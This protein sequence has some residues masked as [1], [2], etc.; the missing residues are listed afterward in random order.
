MRRALAVLVALALLAPAAAAVATDRLSRV[1]ELRGV[2]SATGE[3]DPAELDAALAALFALA[4]DEIVENL[5]AGEPFGSTAFIQERLDAFM[6]AW[7]G[8]A[9]RVH[10]LGGDSRA[11]ALT[12]GVFTL[13]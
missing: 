9:F 8:A 6:A 5:R 3:T 4:D 1:E 2:L 11:G 7:G 12:V 10:R 13:P